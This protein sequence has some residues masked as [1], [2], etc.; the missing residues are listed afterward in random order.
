MSA[1]GSRTRYSSGNAQLFCA[2]SELW[3][4]K[5]AACLRLTRAWLVK[6]ASLRDAGFAARVVVLGCGFSCARGWLFEDV[7]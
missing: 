1:L 6:P 7:D 3:L 4:K 5:R 2:G